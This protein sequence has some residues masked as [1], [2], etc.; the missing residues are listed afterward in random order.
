M[1]NAP[2][3]SSG[4][5]TKPPMPPAA[6]TK[7]L[8]SPRPS[9][10]DRLSPNSGAPQRCTGRNAGFCAARFVA[11]ARTSRSRHMVCMIPLWSRSTRG[12]TP[13]QPAVEDPMTSKE[14]TV[15]YED[16]R[17]IDIRVGRIVQV[18]DF[19]QARKPAFKVRIDFGPLGVKT[20]S[21]QITTHFAKQDLLG[22]MVMA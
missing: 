5:A 21:A 22:R 18:D 7:L 2:A 17:K 16:F 11:A 4:T 6:F 3:G 1:A 15:S 14:D 8:N 19:P 10:R 20:T 13:K 12:A 9:P